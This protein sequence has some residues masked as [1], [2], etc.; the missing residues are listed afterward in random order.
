MSTQRSQ[1][2]RRVIIFIAHCRHP[3][4]SSFKVQAGLFLHFPL[5]SEELSTEQEKIGGR[6]RKNYKKGLAESRRDS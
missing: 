1:N 4:P 5:Y 6:S 3:P 2:A